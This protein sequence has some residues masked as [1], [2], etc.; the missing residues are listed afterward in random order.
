MCSDGSDM[1]ACAYSPQ[2]KLH[3]ELHQKENGQQDEGGNSVPLL[4]SSETSPGMLC[5]AV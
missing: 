5:S 2:T 3:P 1:M 4:C